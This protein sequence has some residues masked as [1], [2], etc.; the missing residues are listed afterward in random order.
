M[1]GDFTN[2][3]DLYKAPKQLAAYNAYTN[4]RDTSGKTDAN[5]ELAEIKRRLIKTLM[6]QRKTM[7][8]II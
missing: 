1:T 3:S 8:I 4:K 7:R 2:L 6:Q 5:K